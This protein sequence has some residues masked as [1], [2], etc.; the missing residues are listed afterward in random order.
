MNNKPSKNK[1]VGII[2]VSLVILV[3]W[4][5]AAQPVQGSNEEERRVEEAI[6]VFQEIAGLTDEGIPESILRN[7]QGIAIIAEFLSSGYRI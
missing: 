1:R 6:R 3:P 7:A 4:L 5:R 2:L